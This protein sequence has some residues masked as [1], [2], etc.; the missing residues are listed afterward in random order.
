MPEGGVADAGA[1]T[2]D[3]AISAVEIMRIVFM[4]CP[5]SLASRGCNLLLP[6]SRGTSLRRKGQRC[7]EPGVL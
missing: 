7:D 6:G 1:A 5:R 3:D 2:I 4:A